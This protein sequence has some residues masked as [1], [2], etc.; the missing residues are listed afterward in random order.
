M[1]TEAVNAPALDEMPDESLVNLA[2]GQKQSLDS[3]SDAERRVQGYGGSVYI[4]I[5][6][7]RSHIEVRKRLRRNR[8]HRSR[9]LRFGEHEGNR[10]RCGITAQHREI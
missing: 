4:H 1:S 9:T 7:V 5:Q 3:V 2:L 10:I 8:D 6:E